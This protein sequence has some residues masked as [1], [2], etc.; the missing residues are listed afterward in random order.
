MRC[1]QAQRLLSEAM[2]EP[3]AA[4]PVQAEA[5]A[6]ACPRCAAF[7]Q[8]AR[9]IR[10]S[11]RFELAPAV[12]DLAPAIME[13][14]A[15]GQAD[16]GGLRSPAARL[17]AWV[18]R[19]AG[20]YSGRRAVA[21]GLAAG[22]VA[23]FVVTGGGLVGTRKN[24]TAALAAEIPQKLVRAAEAIS[25]YRATFRILERNWAPS[26]PRRT[27]VARVAFRAPEGFRVEVSDTTTY[28]P[29]PW[30]HNDASLVTNG[31]SW[32]A[33]GPEPCPAGVPPPCP[34]SARVE[35]V[36]TGRPPFDQSSPMPTDVIVP[37]TVLAA[38]D[39]VRVLGP[40]RVGS[41][42]AVAVQ[43]A[44]QDATPLFA[45]LTFLGSWRPLYPQDRVVVWLDRETWFPLRYEVFPAAG[46][47]RARW[48]R[49]AGLPRESPDRPVFE[50]VARFVS[51]S[52]PSRRAF[53]V[54]RAG[55]V[56]VS[57]L[58]EG[59]EDLP[60]YVLETEGS[61]PR[62][63]RPAWT[64]GLRLV[65]FGLLPATESRPYRESM[66]GYADGVAWLTVTQVTGWNERRAFGVGPFAQ[67]VALPQGT[68]ALYEP[69]TSTDARRIAL[70][71]GRAEYLVAGNLPL[72]D[73]ARVA[74]SLPVHAV[75]E[76]QRWRVHRW[77]GGV[78]EDGLTVRQAVRRAR[79]P[80]LLPDRLP[81]G[82][83]AAAAETV[84]TP[85]VEGLTV[86]FRRPGAELDGVGLRLYQA[87]GQSLPP[88]SSADERLVGVR[89]ATGRWS[90]QE[91]Q[92]EWV[93][94]GVY[95]SLAGPSFDLGG[96]LRVA[97][98]LLPAGG[99][100]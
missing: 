25:G 26:V 28:P 19:G 20:S 17:P 77:S 69:A 83:R 11:V 71:T 14:I 21:A 41:R 100:G 24:G 42:P 64:A 70:H 96:M 98:S 35:Q 99:A 10:R 65:R 79:F 53:A 90:P 86:V 23:G 36:V 84:R 44:Y 57:T 27:F 49:Q 46:T 56:G 48:A 94:A 5:H 52:V 88:P 38:A 68:Q 32:R 40:D 18:R 73:L 76:P 67:R 59:F 95:R 47:E 13:R 60:V 1:E 45:Y 37:M 51:T 16:T 63:P 34:G 15:A 29:G 22:L 54:P 6:G 81:T 8:G 9:R 12:P 2:D 33:A 87:A 58:D 91:H 78:V 62:P 43:M 31:R 50:A 55:G 75:A 89:G 30:T 4:A 80:V 93:E 92:L 66:Q 72:A 39:R 74:G 61:P 82:Y 3:A 97:G 85:D 7:V